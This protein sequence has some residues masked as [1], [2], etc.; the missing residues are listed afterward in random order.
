MSLLKI[1]GETYIIDL[2][3]MNEAIT[4]LTKENENNS[5]EE[6]DTKLIYENPNTENEKLVMKEIVIRE[7]NKEKKIDIAKY[8]MLRLLLD[9]VMGYNDELDDTLGA[10]RAM[11]KMPISFKIAF[12]TLKYYRVL[13]NIDL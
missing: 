2:T 9:V 8:E 12:N 11:G 7:Y 1:G 3:A 5:G 13:R 4:E 10:E 6:K